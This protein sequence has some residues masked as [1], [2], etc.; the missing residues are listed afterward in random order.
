[1]G[2]L[3][4]KI[5]SYTKACGELTDISGDQKPRVISDIKYII[6]SEMKYIIISEIKYIIISDIKYIIIS[7]MK[8][9]RYK[10]YHN[11]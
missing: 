1:V 10:I 5:D 11:K 8:Y 2:R 9:K 7:E 3:L 6:I 4:Q